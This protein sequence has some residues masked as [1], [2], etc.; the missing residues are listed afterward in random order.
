MSAILEAPTSRKLWATAL[1]IAMGLE[2]VFGLDKDSVATVSGA[3]ATRAGKCS[4][5]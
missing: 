3:V 4:S 2:M 5:K 1:R